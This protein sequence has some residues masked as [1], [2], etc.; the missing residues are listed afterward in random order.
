MDTKPGSLPKSNSADSDIKKETLPHVLN[1]CF[2]SKT[3]GY[4]LRHNCLV[5][6]IKKAAERDFTI[7]YENQRIPGTDLRPD[8]VIENATK[9]FVIDVT[10]A[11]EHRREAF[12]K[13]RQ[14]K[15]D[16]YN[17]LIELM[18]KPGKTVEIV[19]FVMGSCGS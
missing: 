16:T 13:A 14:R 5:D 7:V 19:P 17:C 9:I 11:Y 12:D 10:V 2:G 18:K 1:H 3:R 6:R 4:Q 8:L 15:H